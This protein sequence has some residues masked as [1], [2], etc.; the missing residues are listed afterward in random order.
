LLFL[1]TLLVLA[2]VRR[3]REPL[4][5]GLTRLEARV[6]GTGSQSVVTFARGVLESLV[7][8]TQRREVASVLFWTLCVWL[9]GGAVNQLLF[10]A[11]NI[12]VPW[13][14]AWLVMVALQLGT[15]IPALPAN[16]GV[17][18]YV[19]ILTLG[20]YGVNESAALAYAILLH[21]IVFVLPAF[22]GAVCA[23]PLSARLL[24]LVSNGLRRA[25]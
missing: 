23:L 18:H 9:A 2:S 16:L 19:T 20:F 12:S 10:F 7:N 5:K 14:A 17:F 25:V 13:S 21:L 4:L 15:R 22:I 3:L 24:S 11:L 8:L 6:L 1:L